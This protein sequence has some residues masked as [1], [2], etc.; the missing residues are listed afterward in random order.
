MADILRIRFDGGN[1]YRE[2]VIEKATRH[3][4]KNTSTVAYA[5]VAVVEI[6]RTVEEVPPREGF[7]HKWRRELPKRIRHE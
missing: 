2:D 7:T 6:V 1:R 4:G 3:Y 5:C